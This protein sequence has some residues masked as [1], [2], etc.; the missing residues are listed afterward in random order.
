MNSAK[1]ILELALLQE[2][3]EKNKDQNEQID[4]LNDQIERCDQLESDAESEHELHD[5][6]SEQ[7]DCETVGDEFETVDEL[8]PPE[9]EIFFNNTP[10][11]RGKDKKTMWFK[12]APKV[13]GRTKIQ[14]L[15]VKIPGVKGIAREAKTPL[16]CWKL[17]F[18]DD[19][20]QEIVDYTNVYLGLMR[21]NYGRGRDCPDTNYDE[22]YALLG[23]LYLTGVK[24]S[25]DVDIS[26]LW[27]DDG[28]GPECFRS[29]MSYRRFYTLLRALRFDDHTDRNIRMAQDNLAPIRKQF[30]GFVERCKKNYQIGLYGTV[31]EML[32][33]FRGRCKF[34]KYIANKPAKYGIKIYALVDSTTFYTSN[35][36]IYA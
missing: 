25:Q 22:I 28:T 6:D 26:E 19:S 32:E 8:Q 36:E 4:D 20:I 33:A 7:S 12:H 16:E 13:Y 15:V 34:R 21:K 29:T 10:I 2:A 1:R 17:F 14:N 27:T 30:D 11:F 35:L 5:T 18:P 23:L 24:K 3:Q 9:G 31:D